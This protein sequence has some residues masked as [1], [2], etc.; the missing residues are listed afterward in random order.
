MRELRKPPSP[1]LF[2][3]LILPLGIVVVG[4]NFTA[5][6]LLLAQAGVPVDRIASISS[7]INLPGVIGFLFAPIVDI[8]FRRRTWLVLAS[9]GTALSACLYFPLIGAS[10]LI[11][12]T[13]LV[14]AGGLITFLVGAACG[15][16]IVK[17]LSESA[18]SK[19]AG[20][21]MAGQLGGGALGAAVILWL[22]AR[23][24]VAT[25]GVCVAILVALPGL[26]AFTIAEPSPQPSAWFQGR[27]P[28][29]GK[30]LWA[31]VRSPE[32]RWGTLLLLAPGG[33]GA[34]QI[35]LPA[36]ASHYGVGTSGVM[37]MN[38][39]GGGALLALGS[40]GGALIPGNWDRRFTYAAAGLTNALAAFVLLVA[41]RPS[42]YLAG[43]ALYLV[44]Q[45]LCW[46]RSTALVVE[47]VGVETGDASTLY[48]VL[49]AIVTIPL[50]YMIRL[51]GFGFGRFGMHG[52]LWIDAGANLLVF[53]VVAVV[54]MAYGLKLRRVADSHAMARASTIP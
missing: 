34:A 27:L 17:T 32:R 50:L 25:V 35:L 30:E 5:F 53:G 12:M 44:T 1:W 14:L 28:Q 33:T 39:V 48:S 47:I 36:V 6:P 19:A 4:F 20:W 37:W 21:M 11:L 41:N 8:K 42:I 7:I 13:A 22:A 49:N 3:L 26:V 43:T 46:A 54:F 29:I 9:F 38:G 18:Q 51:D 40:L 31:V 45:G 10:H 2:S 52:L 23:V 16:L 15:G 24:P